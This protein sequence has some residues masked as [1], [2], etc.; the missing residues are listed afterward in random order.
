MTPNLKTAI[1]EFLA[2][3]FKLK[4]EEVREDLSFTNDLDLNPGQLQDL[5]ERLQEALDFI[6]PEEK[7]PGIETIFDLLTAAEPEPDNHETS[8]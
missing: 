8:N 2:N 4:P 3:E 6:L 1:L 7:I 5:L